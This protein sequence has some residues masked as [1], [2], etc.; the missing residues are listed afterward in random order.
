MSPIRMF[1]ILA[2]ATLVGAAAD[3]AFAQG[4]SIESAVL[5]SRSAKNLGVTTEQGQMADFFKAQKAVT[6]G[7]LRSAGISLDQLPPDVRARIER[8]QTT[9]LEAFRAFSQGLDLK[10]Q[11]RF[12]EAKEQFRRAAELDPGFGLAVEQ[13]Q[14]MP[15]VNV[16]TSVQM[17]AVVA[18]A[19]NSAV[20]RGR[21]GYVVDLAHAQAA[22]QA[23]QTVVLQAAPA[24]TEQLLPMEYTI[25]TPGSGD[26][27][28]QSQN[29]VA[30]LSYSVAPAGGIAVTSEWPGGKYRTNGGILESV[31]SDGLSAQRGSA[32]VGNSG[33]PGSA[34]LADG[35][36]TAYWGT[37]LSRGSNTASLTLAAGNTSNTYTAASGLGNIDYVMA[38]ATRQMPGTGTASFTPVPFAGS[39]GQPAGTIQVDFLHQNIELQNLAF[40]IGGLSFSGLTG[41]SSY[42]SPLGSGAFKGSY[43]D[44]FCSGCKSF[45]PASSGF[46]GNFVGLN[47]AGLIFST[48]MAADGSTV[49]G[50]NLFD[51]KKP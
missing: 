42:A 31:S 38:Q 18:I 27:F 45:S 46:T 11:G 4:F 20:D 6:F 22:L 39:L 1:R 17:R 26:Q 2:A 35:A 23:G 44:G 19:S 13:Q 30:A 37:W 25:N 34:L 16:S 8:F 28:V 50:V 9:N 3:A 12:A 48:I 14:A 43:S 7:I 36:T 33:T 40:S 47:A 29:L 15:D 51:R 32:T 49:S 24:L 5:D 21:Q 10:D 41:S